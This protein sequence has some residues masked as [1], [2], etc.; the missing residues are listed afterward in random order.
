MRNPEPAWIPDSETI[1]RANVTD[2]AAQLGL[3]DYEALHRWSAEH[4]AEFWQAVIDRLGIAFRR[5]PSAI[6]AQPVDPR[7]P[8]WLPGASLNIVESCFQAP[9]GATAV[10]YRQ[11]GTLHRLTYGQLER[12]VAEKIG[13][14]NFHAYYFYVV[15][16]G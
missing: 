5:R 12:R 3:G 10:V 4:R 1:A 11:H 6:L 14:K 8:E 7:S 16:P 13:F 15:K 2:F 9:P